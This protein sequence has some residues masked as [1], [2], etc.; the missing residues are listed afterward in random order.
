MSLL[1]KQGSYPQNLPIKT[2]G[3]KEVE[4][5][6]YIVST[7]DFVQMVIYVMTN[8]DLVKNDQRLVLQKL[9]SSLTKTEGYNE[10]NKRLVIKSL[11]KSKKSTKI[12]K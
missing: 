9:I 4:I 8:T 5:G 7:L 11:V 2:W 6:D 12:K 10:G 1:L 3:A